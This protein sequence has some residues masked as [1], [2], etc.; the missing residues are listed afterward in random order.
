[1]IARMPIT[2]TFTCLHQEIIGDAGKEGPDPSLCMWLLLPSWS[3]GHALVMH[4]RHDQM[5][6]I[7]WFVHWLVECL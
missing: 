7:L 3:C 5:I 6:V 1:M 4:S 2:S